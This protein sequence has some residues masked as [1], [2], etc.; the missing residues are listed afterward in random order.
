MDEA[1]ADHAD[2]GGAQG[3]DQ[4]AGGHRDRRHDADDRFAGHDVGNEKPT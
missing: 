4:D 1:V 3:A 2:G